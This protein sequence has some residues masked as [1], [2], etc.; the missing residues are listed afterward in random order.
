[1]PGLTDSILY[2]NPD[3]TVSHKITHTL[4][5]YTYTIRNNMPPSPHAHG[6]DFR[7]VLCSTAHYPHSTSTS[8]KRKRMLINN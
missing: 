4:F 6:N 7:I 3:H 8:L 1:M 5:I 2:E